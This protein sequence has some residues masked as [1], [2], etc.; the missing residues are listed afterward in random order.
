MPRPWHS[1]RSGR[2][3]TPS[4][5][6][7]RWSPGEQLDRVTGYPEAGK[8]A[9]ARALVGGERVGESGYYVEPTVFV[10]A[11]PDMSIVREEIFGPVAVALPFTDEDEVIDAANDTVYGPAAGLWTKDLSR[12]HRVAA[13]LKAGR[14]WINTFHAFDAG[15]PFGGYGQ[16]G[17]GR[18]L[19]SEA[20]AL[21]TRVKAVNIAL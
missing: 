4:R 13:R 12:A 20:L 11:T 15:L 6:S 1:S 16:S 19:G 14:V 17:W 2:A 5:P 18:E 9:G 10:D 3:P 21:Y 7:R 8:A